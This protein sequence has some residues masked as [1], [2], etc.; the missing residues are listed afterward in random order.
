MQSRQRGRYNETGQ[1]EIVS[2]E[3]LELEGRDL[4]LCDCECQDARVLN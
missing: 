2:R 3:K 1:G 4:I